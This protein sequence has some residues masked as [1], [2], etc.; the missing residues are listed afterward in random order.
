MQ[1]A[2]FRKAAF[3]FGGSLL[4]EGDGLQFRLL[5]RFMQVTK[6]HVLRVHS[7]PAQLCIPPCPAMCTAQSRSGDHVLDG[8]I[9]VNSCRVEQWHAIDLISCKDQR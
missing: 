2:A 6:V 9:D 7:E 5:E 8:S 1:K 4:G 3:S